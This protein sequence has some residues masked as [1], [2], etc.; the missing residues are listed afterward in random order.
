MLYRKVTIHVD[1]CTK[2]VKYIHARDVEYAR[3]E[4]GDSL[5]VHNRWKFSFYWAQRH[6]LEAVYRKWPNLRPQREIEPH[7]RTARPPIPLLD[8]HS[9]VAGAVSALNNALVGHHE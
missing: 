1:A 3:E 5:V 7:V 6:L 4:W 8:D 9:T 2:V